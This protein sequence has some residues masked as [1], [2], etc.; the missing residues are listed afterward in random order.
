MGTAMIVFNNYCSTL[1]FELQENTSAARKGQRSEREKS[2]FFFRGSIWKSFCREDRLRQS[3]QLLLVHGGSGVDVQGTVSVHPA[4]LGDF[5]VDVNIPRI[6]LYCHR[7]HRIGV[8][9][10][11]RGDVRSKGV[12][13]DKKIAGFYRAV[14]IQVLSGFIPINAVGKGQTVDVVGKQTA[15]DAGKPFRGLGQV[16]Q[17][18]RLR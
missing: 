12:A 10:F 15:V 3:Y 5:R 1:R 8:L 14:E 13:A 6:A 9:Q 4:N 2:G 7:N 16:K 17:L 18:H 11:L